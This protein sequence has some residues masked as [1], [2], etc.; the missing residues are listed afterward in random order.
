MMT[1]H[2]PGRVVPRYGQ[3]RMD[4]SGAVATM[5]GW[6][7]EI[8]DDQLCR[9]LDPFFD[10][11]WCVDALLHALRSRPDGAAHP[12][13][14]TSRRL[15]WVRYRL[16]QWRARDGHP[17]SAPVD[18]DTGTSSQQSVTPA[19]GV[20]PRMRGREWPRS[21]VPE[22]AEQEHAATR[23]LR[24]DMR[25]EDI[26]DQEL[27]GL[28][29]RF[30]RA[31]WSVDCL[32]HAVQTNPLTGKTDPSSERTGQDRA[33]W[34]KERLGRWLGR[35]GVPKPPPKAT[36]SYSEWYDKQ[37]EAGTF[38]VRERTR[39]RSRTQV[40][41]VR[42]SREADSRRR[43]DRAKDRIAD[44]RERDR[45]TQDSLAALGTRFW[46]PAEG[47]DPGPTAARSRHER[48][49]E[50][51]FY[52][53]ATNAGIVRWLRELVEMDPDKIGPHTTA[54]TRARMRDARVQASLAGLESISGGAELSSLAGAVS[55][56]VASGADV[57]AG[58]EVREMWQVLRKAFHD[59][60]R[61]SRASP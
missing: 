41:S 30:F 12:H 13:V 25:W 22:S 43:W 11:D 29:G 21:V 49:I 45:R 37:R 31:N 8:A 18:A 59:H 42:Q 50:S 32:E 40:E 58:E 17:L 20:A 26:T 24:Q 39:G 28:V 57:A 5:E 27:L 34:L 6:R 15:D 16:N 46:E 10:A 4:A 19:T 51:I 56:H 38:D 52:L 7:G 47:V 9:E 60:G 14:R 3:A 44:S 48:L 23:L 61:R 53:E 2:W 35:G 54:V 55:S 36:L 33:T 1:Q